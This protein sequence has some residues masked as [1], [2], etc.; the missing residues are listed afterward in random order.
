MDQHGKPTSP[1]TQSSQLTSYLQDYQLIIRERHKSKKNNVSGSQLPLGLFNCHKRARIMTGRGKTNELSQLLSQQ[2]MRHEKN[3]AFDDADWNNEE[4]TQEL[5][6]EEQ[7]HEM[8]ANKEEETSPKRKKQCNVNQL[9]AKDCSF[10]QSVVFEDDSTYAEHSMESSVCSCCH[11]IGESKETVQPRVLKEISNTFVSFPVHQ[12]SHN[13]RKQSANA[14][15]TNV[16]SAN[17]KCANVQRTN[18]FW[19]P[20]RLS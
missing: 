9:V 7:T 19:R 16:Q 3:I 17:M 5:N 10:V 12:A 6:N 8:D 14:Q 11:V 20:Y 1:N 13:N 18:V 4:Q 2:Y 15:S